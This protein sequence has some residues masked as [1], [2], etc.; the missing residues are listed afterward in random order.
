MSVTRNALAP[1][2]GTP[3]ASVAIPGA[4]GRRGSGADGVP[5]S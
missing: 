2:G 4:L 1:L 3:S 5:L